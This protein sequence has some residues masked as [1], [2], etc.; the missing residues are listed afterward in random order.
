MQGNF[1]GTCRPE[2]FFKMEMSIL[3][4][5]QT[6]ISFVA[7]LI[8]MCIVRGVLGVDCITL[9]TSQ[10]LKLRKVI[11]LMIYLGSK[12][13]NYILNIKIYRLLSSKSFNL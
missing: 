12:I 1:L 7:H 2:E 5:C 6:K 13:L 10:T 9:Q 8:I 11:A 3:T 4:K